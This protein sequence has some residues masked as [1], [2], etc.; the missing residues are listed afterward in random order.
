MRDSLV[1]IPALLS[2]C[3]M[4]ANTNMFDLLMQAFS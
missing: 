1:A 3:V 4:Q 2:S